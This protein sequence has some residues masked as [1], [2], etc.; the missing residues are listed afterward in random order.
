MKHKDSKKKQFK[1]F[2][3][4]KMNLQSDVLLNKFKNKI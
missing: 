3:N 4:L 1:R 2:S